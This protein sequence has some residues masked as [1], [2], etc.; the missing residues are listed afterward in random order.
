MLRMWQPMHYHV[1][2]RTFI[3]F[4][5][6]SSSKSTPKQHPSTSCHAGISGHYL[7]LRELDKAVQGY[8]TAGLAPSSYQTYQSAE[9]RYLVFCKNFALVP[10]PTSEQ[11]LCYFTACLGQ[12]GLAHSTIKTYLSGV[13]QLQV[14]HGGEDPGI[15][16]MPRLQQV[17][18]GVKAECGKR[19]KPTRSRLPIIPG[20]LRKMKMS[21]IGKNSFE[22]VMLWAASL[23]TFFSFCH[24]GEVTVEKEDKCDPTTHLSFSD[25]AADSATSPSVI[26]LNIKYSKTDQGRV[27]C[28][29]ATLQCLLKIVLL[30]SP[31]LID[32]HPIL[33]H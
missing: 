6:G 28:Q 20:I 13:C 7:D 1:T 5:S 3:L 14:A 9:H 24:S 31:I 21:W 32:Y 11:I 18:R 27:G 25:G 30:L 22:S 29:I 12:Q 26:S 15:D 17:L 2:R 10:P 16:K 19:G 23:T 4:L 33:L 8:F